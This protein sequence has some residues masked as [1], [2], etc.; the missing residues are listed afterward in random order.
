[1]QK[2]FVP[3][4]CTH[5]FQIHSFCILALSNPHEILYILQVTR[6]LSVCRRQSDIKY[7][8]FVNGKILLFNIMGWNICVEWM[9]YKVDVM[10]GNQYEFRLQKFYSC[11][12]LTCRKM[13]LFYLF[14]KKI[15]GKE[16]VRRF[17]IFKSIHIYLKSYKTKSFVWRQV[18]HY[19]FHC[20]WLN[21][22]IMRI[23]INLI[24]W[25]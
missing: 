18:I 8:H 11:Y 9:E 15:L 1:M 25:N 16:L 24:G 12:R 22:N 23:L 13:N 3:I 17:M 6:E 7:W 19:F 2:L 4:L 21:P 10:E 14:L 5:I 20:N